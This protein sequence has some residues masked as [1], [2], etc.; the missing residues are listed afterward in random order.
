LILSSF[1]YGYASLREHHW[2]ITPRRHACLRRG[3]SRTP[4]LSV[5][6]INTPNYAES[7]AEI[8]PPSYL[9]T[10][11]LK[12]RQRRLEP[13]FIAMPLQYASRRH[14]SFHATTP[15]PRP[16]PLHAAARRRHSRHIVQPRRRLVAAATPRQVSHATFINTTLSLIHHYH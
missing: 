4:T 15:P 7:F 8:L 5:L 1:E 3:A 11:W 9:A 6:L 13:S 10:N 2:R 14:V 12:A 16:P